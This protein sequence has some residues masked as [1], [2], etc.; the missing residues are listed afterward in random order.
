MTFRSLFAAAVLAMAYAPAVA[1]GTLAACD[2]G[3][4][5]ESPPECSSASVTSSASTG[6]GEQCSFAAANGEQCSKDC[7]CHGKA[8][9][10]QGVCAAPVKAPPKTE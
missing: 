5:P 4:G 10:V 9:T 3:Q 1:L 8:C 6:T 7:D 2:P